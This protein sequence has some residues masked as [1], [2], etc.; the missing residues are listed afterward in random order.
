MNYRRRRFYLPMY[1]LL[2]DLRDDFL[3]LRWKIWEQE[4]RSNKETN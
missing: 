2:V 3:E 4:R 1:S